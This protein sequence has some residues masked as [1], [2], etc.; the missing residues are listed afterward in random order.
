[1]SRR[2][3]SNKICACLVHEIPLI[4]ELIALIAKSPSI[5]ADFLALIAKV[6]RLLAKPTVA[7]RKY[8]ILY[9]PNEINISITLVSITETCCKTAQNYSKKRSWY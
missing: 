9:I 6:H 2:K 8:P 4:A 7:A 1:M 5:I 3:F